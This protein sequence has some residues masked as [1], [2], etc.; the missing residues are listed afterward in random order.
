MFAQFELGVEVKD[1][2]EF[3]EDYDLFSKRHFVEL[4]YED[5]KM[6]SP[7]RRNAEAM[8]KSPKNGE[9]VGKV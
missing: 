2:F 8:G 1:L 6:R 7:S 4:Q 9:G 5:R 3:L